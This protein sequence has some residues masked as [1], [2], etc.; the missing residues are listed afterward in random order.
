LVHGVSPFTNE[1]LRNR[2]RG[3]AAMLWIRIL[4]ACLVFFIIHGYKTGGCNSLFLAY[5]IQNMNSDCR[6][7]SSGRR[8][9]GTKYKEKFHDSDH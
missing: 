6:R 8:P 7:G 3:L 9:Y 2:I 1:A 4:K 5:L